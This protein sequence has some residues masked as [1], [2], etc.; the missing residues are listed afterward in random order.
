MIPGGYLPAIAQ[1]VAP[2]M[3]ST[4][5]PQ[6]H[7]DR[8]PA[9]VEPSRSTGTT[10]TIAGASN[11]EGESDE[12]TGKKK[13]RLYQ[14]QNNAIDR[15]KQVVKD[16]EAENH[17]IRIDNRQLEYYLA[18]ARL[19]GSLSE[20]DNGEAAVQAALQGMVPLGGLACRREQHEPRRTSIADITLPD[21]RSMPLGGMNVAGITL[22]VQPKP[23]PARRLRQYERQM[24]NIETLRDEKTALKD[25]NTALRAENQLL[26]EL[27]AK[28][29]QFIPS[30]ST[31]DEG[32]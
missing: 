19:L 26:E 8:K 31:V 24:K 20:S 5:A 16:M 12:L 13:L 27:L 6:E 25:Q 2:K 29:A 18:Q 23:P 30:S 3:T 1:A 14:K 10:T 17:R 15:L 4:T 7:T 32:K 28:T 22:P 11:D 9:A 21:V